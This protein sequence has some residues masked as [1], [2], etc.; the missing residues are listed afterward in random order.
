MTERRVCD[1]KEDANQQEKLVP[2]VLK[3]CESLLIRKNQNFKRKPAYWW[4][5]DIEQLRSACNKARR[6][7][8]RWTMK[9]FGNRQNQTK[10]TEKGYKKN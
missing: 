7:Y 4:S 10:R 6:Q 8:Q 3:A 9:D 5:S 1:M 2:Q